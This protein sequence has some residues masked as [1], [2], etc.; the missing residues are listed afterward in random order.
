M[1]NFK[2]C[3]DIWIKKF[4]SKVY[5]EKN[6]KKIIYDHPLDKR[7][8]TPAPHPLDKRSIAQNPQFLFIC[9]HFTVQFPSFRSYTSAKNLGMML[10]VLRVTVNEKFPFKEI[11]TS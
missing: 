10:P 2:T 8:T 7:S 4:L 1:V 6:V 11:L 9:K 3:K 5:D